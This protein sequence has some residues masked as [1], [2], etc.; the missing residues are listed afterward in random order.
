M[1]AVTKTSLPTQGTLSRILA[2]AA[3][4]PDRVA[5]QDDR[6]RLSYAQLVERTGAVAAGL[7]RAGIRPGDRVALLLDNSAAFVTTALGCMWLGATFVPLS[8]ADPA[9]RHS[10]IV[11]DCQPSLLVTWGP[12][13]A[14]PELDEGLA[15]LQV[16]GPDVL[17]RHPEAP[18]APAED[19]G[20]DVYII[21]TSG[22]TGTPKGVRISDRAL[23]HAVD[24]TL[25]ALGLDGATRSVPVS[26]FHFDGSYGNLF[27]TL[28]GGGALLVPPRAQLL[29]LK[30]FFVTVEQE[31]VTHTSCS[32]SYTRMLM[33]SPMAA[34]LRNSSL[35][36][37]VMGGEQLYASDVAGLWELMPDL[38]VVNCYGP[39]ETT[40]AVSFH[41]VTR[42]DVAAGKV[43]LGRPNPGVGFHL[44]GPDGELIEENGR[45]GELYISGGQLMSGYWGDPALTAKAVRD[46]VVPGRL[47]YKTG[48][49]AYRDSSGLYIY[50]GRLD[51]VVKRRGQRISLS[52]VTE[53]LRRVDGVT[54]A[55]CMTA[56]ISGQLGIVAFVETNEPMTPLGVLEGA[57][58]NLGEWM[59][60]DEVHVVGALPTGPTGKVDGRRLLADHGYQQWA[61]RA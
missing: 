15:G 20:R 1:S 61:E 32:P 14:G 56:D 59:R 52:E 41:E 2:H 22:T 40:I 44:V 30:R 39:T 6:E 55:I 17:H 47:A 48:D 43:P 27:P 37:W 31:R 12:E 10:R 46:D 11:N 3:E 28:V 13:E 9:G 21:Y 16:V 33:A 60:P 5:V 50:C 19:L 54:G 4:A 45:T 18:P 53:A 25:G 34:R 51:D 26:S 58:D 23:G 36:S 38:R 49:L 35:R 29:F 8:P 24:A 42:Q 7:R 57:R